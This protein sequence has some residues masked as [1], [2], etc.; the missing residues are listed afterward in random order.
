MAKLR[1]KTRAVIDRHPV[2][3]EIELAKD[4]AERLEAINY[5]AILGEVKAKPKPAAKKKPTKKTAKK[6]DKDKK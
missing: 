2:G 6:D 4:T 3:S 1:V 5:V